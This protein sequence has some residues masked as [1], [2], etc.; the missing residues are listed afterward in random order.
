MLAVAE[1][2]HRQAWCSLRSLACLCSQ[3]TSHVVWSLWCLAVADPCT[4]HPAVL[5]NSTGLRRRFGWE[6]RTRRY[7]QSKA[8]G[9]PCLPG[10]L[11]HSWEDASIPVLSR[12]KLARCARSSQKLEAIASGLPASGPQSASLKPLTA[13][14]AP[15]R[16]GQHRQHLGYRPFRQQ[17]ISIRQA[18]AHR[19]PPEA[20]AARCICHKETGD[21]ARCARSSSL[22][23]VT[24]TGLRAEA[25]GL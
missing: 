8:T 9:I 18:D 19:S 3:T 22:R 16:D 23:A 1:H 20:P 14:E 10:L 6:P 15:A 11:A 21:C 17:S 7:K 4:Q 12:N 2:Q 13:G 25:I 5:V 24:G